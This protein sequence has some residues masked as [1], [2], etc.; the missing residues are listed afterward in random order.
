MMNL[1]M[2]IK[3]N[4]KR[5][6]KK[7]RPGSVKEISGRESFNKE[8]VKDIQCITTHIYNV[9]IRGVAYSL[10]FFEIQTCLVTAQV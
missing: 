5:R 9:S 10:L 2:S 6:R 7:V 3:R 8:G 4:G 1:E